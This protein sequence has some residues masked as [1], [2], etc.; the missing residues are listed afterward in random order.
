MSSG[1]GVYTLEHK[2]AASHRQGASASRSP[3]RKTREER[4]GVG[5]QGSGV[6][7]DVA[8]EHSQGKHGT[9]DSF[10]QVRHN[11]EKSYR[12]SR[13]SRLAVFTVVRHAI[14]VG[15]GA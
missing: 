9:Q 14:T 2:A 3:N 5:G 10:M 13:P 8:L 6:G 1:G 4:G 15:A 11:E 7:L 12:L